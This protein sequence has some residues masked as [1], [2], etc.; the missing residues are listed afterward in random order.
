MT[1]NEKQIKLQQLKAE[2]QA[3]HNTIQRKK[4]EVN[5]MKM[6]DLMQTT[7]EY[8]ECKR[9]LVSQIDALR[10]K[11]K[12]LDYDDPRRFDIEDEARSLERMLS[13]KR[14]EHEA[15]LHRINNFHT[16]TRID[17]DNEERTLT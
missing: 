14:T 2:L 16:M 7:D 13:L 12:A 15:V 4:D 10:Q 1:E 17:L 5:K 6:K 8:Y 9:D 3:K 11:K